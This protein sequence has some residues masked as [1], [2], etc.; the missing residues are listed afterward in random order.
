MV[1]GLCD[2]LFNLGN[3]KC[4][5]LINYCFNLKTV[6]GYCLQVIFVIFITY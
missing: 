3:K 6:V 1:F 4:Y 5:C 2:L